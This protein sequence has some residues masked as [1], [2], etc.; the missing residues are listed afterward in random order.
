MTDQTIDLD[1]H[2]APP[3]QRATELRR[4]RVEVL[5][6]QALIKAR[7]D[8]F[9]AVLVAAPSA[10]WPEAAEKA[11]YLLA[12]YAESGSVVDPR[13]RQLISDVIADFDRL[14]GDPVPPQGS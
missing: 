2:R 3:D 9:E 4:L 14:L 12:L 10:G 5:N 1:L 11:R 7:Q 8:A 6:D 13:R